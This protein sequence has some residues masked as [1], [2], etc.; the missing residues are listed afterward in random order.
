MNSVCGAPHFLGERFSAIDLYL[1]AM[2]HWRPGRKWWAAETP[3]LLAAADAASAMPEVGKVFAR[4][5]K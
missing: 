3:K 5:F 1:A 2:S 4:H